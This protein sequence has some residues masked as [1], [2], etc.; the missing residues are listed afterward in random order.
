MGFVRRDGGDRLSCQT[1]PA[2]AGRP[3]HDEYLL[4]RRTAASNIDPM[5][6]LALDVGSSSV[7]AAI[8]HRGAVAGRVVRAAFK[9]RYEGNR[10]EVDAGEI[11]KAVAVAIRQLGA[12][13]KKVELIALATMSP[14]WVAMDKAGRAL[15]PIITHQDRRSLEVA[16]DLEKRVGKKRHLSIA[17]VRPIP[18]GISSTTWAW[19]L[20][21]ARGLMK[22]ADLCG[23]LTTLLHRQI[24]HARVVD[25]SHA[26]FMGLYNTMKHDGWND[27]LIEAVGASEHHLPQIM[28]ADEVAGMVTREGGRMF[29]LTHGTPMLAGCVDGSAAML[30][31]G[32]NPGQMVNVCGSTDVLA[33]CTDRPTPHEKLL[34]RSLGIGKMWLSVST[35]ASSGSSLTWAKKNLFADLSE[36]EF[37]KI[38]AGLAGKPIATTVRFD[39]YLA[40]DRT[41][42]EQRQAGFSGLTLSSTREDMLAAIIDALA[43]ASAERL[44]LLQ[45]AG[46]VKLS[47][48]VMMTGGVQE[49]GLNGLLT[50]DWPGKWTFQRED[51]A[52]LRGLG[53]LAPMR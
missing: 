15:T 44:P 37:Y 19:F 49:G 53:R 17:G 12:G 22:R 4:N 45:A 50:R 20:Q 35:V 43:K 10:A 24:T 40:G 3:C 11:L 39:P 13:A 5:N 52:T 48:R 18:G 8:L 21:N 30:L 26:S 31:A 29:G 1:H 51:E 36:K 32:A 23:H 41:S 46:G 47:R 6:L 14:S 28:G 7:K 2:W 27:E 42:V 25:P 16:V 34:T 33:L 38:I 9:T